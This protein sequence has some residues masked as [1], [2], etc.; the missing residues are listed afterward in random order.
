MKKLLS[1]CLV[2]VM[3]MGILSGCGA[4]PQKE[5][6]APAPSPNAEVETPTEGS[7]SEAEFNWIASCA[8]TED[9]PAVQGVMKFAELV[10]EKSDGRIHMD[11]FHSAQ[12]A[13]DRDCIEGMQMNT[14]QSGI[15]VASA[16]ASFTDAFLAFDLPFLFEN[17]EQ[18]QKLCDSEVGKEMLSRLDDIGIKGLG[19]MEYGMRNITNS[20]LPI[21][22]PDDLK[23]I[24]IRTMENPIHMA[25]FSAMGADPTPM[26][27]GE[28]FTA[29]QQ[30]TIDAQENPL[31]VITSS[32]FNE[33]QTY[34]SVTEHVYSAAP[35]MVS[36]TAYDAL[37]ADLQAVVDEAGMEACK[38]E[39]EYLSEAETAWL[40]DLEAAG[41]EINY[42]EKAPFVEATA[43]AYE[44]FVGSGPN[45]IPEELLQQIYGI[46]GKN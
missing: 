46:I 27:F 4:D 22:V 13:S 3:S 41:M 11:V 26:A 21:T 32:K 18:G 8:N 23:G 12:L 36:K 2:L 43:G 19:F 24:K 45:Q 44:E 15:M 33:V 28:L 7:T 16:L 34:L 38:W 17:S 39:R 30:K 9:H 37:P 10:E 25:A 1:L 42:P 14:I 5:E 31:S 40:S 6:T 35:L 20:K 29:L